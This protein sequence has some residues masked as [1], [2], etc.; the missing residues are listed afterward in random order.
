MKAVVYQGMSPF[1]HLSSHLQPSYVDLGVSPS[2]EIQTNWA[3][4]PFKVTIEERPFPKL[5]HPDDALIKVTT[6][7]IC[8][9]DLHMYQGRTAAQGGL[10]FGKLP[11]IAPPSPLSLFIPIFYTGGEYN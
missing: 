4:E 7:A 8:G 1:L 2:Y 3:I 11:S 10:C 9:S 6:A 5:E